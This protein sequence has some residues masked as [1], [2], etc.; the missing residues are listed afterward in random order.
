MFT[1]ALANTMPTGGPADGLFRPLAESSAPRCYRGSQLANEARRRI[2][3]LAIADCD[4]L[5]QAAKARA[6]SANVAKFFITEPSR[7]G[8]IFVEFLN[9]IVPGDDDG[10]LRHVVQLVVTE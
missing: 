6:L 1:N 7:A 5:E 10:K 8:E 4:N 2:L 9:V 3:Y